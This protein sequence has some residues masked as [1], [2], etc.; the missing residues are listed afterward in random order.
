MNI[1]QS[2]LIV[3]VPALVVIAALFVGRSAVRAL[4]GYAAL[5]ATLVFFV[6]VPGD[7]VSAA[8]IGLI[9][10][11]LVAT[12][13]GTAVDEEFPEHHENRKRMTTDPSHALPSELPQG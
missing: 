11:F 13:R 4:F 7:P 12:G 5:A 10:V 8:L 9:A 1:L 6:V 2:W 3:G